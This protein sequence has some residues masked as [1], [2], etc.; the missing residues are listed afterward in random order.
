MIVLYVILAVVV[1]LFMVLIHE[2]GHYTA[3]RILKFKIDEFS[4]GFG[5][6]IFSRTNKRG[7]KISLR[8][9][10]LG[11]Y[12]AFA[13]EDGTDKNGNK[14][15]EGKAFTDQKAWKRIIV[16][17]A[18]AT[19]NFLTAIV[20]SFIL[21]VSV[22]YDIPEFSQAEQMKNIISY[23]YATE[24]NP[25]INMLQEGDV[26]FYVDG[27]KI[28]FAYSYSFPELVSMKTKEFKTWI[29]T[30]GNSFENH[31]PITFS[32]R[33]N[34]QMMDVPLYFTKVTYIKLD[35]NNK[36]IYKKDENNQIV[37]DET[38]TEEG[39]LKYDAY[40]LGGY[41]DIN[42]EN[43]IV[44]DSNGYMTLNYNAYS[45]YRH[46]FLEALA[47]CI[48]FAFGLAWIVLKS[49]WMLITFQVAISEMG[50]PITTIATIATSVQAN[51]ANMLVLIP[52]ISANL[53]VFNLLP[54][55]A[56]DGA[57]VAF[58]TVEWIRRKPINRELENM[59]HTL[60]LL[61]LF[62]FVI[63]VDILHFIL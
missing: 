45:T 18:G 31:K 46:S 9:F 38:T 52:L 11:G 63:L 62:G 15:K 54:V 7:E 44:V 59:I 8:I 5:K 4:I 10:P 35:S 30:E 20:F 34:G 57:H 37:I 55:P 16:F 6:A 19:F 41:I 32:V 1:L 60:G 24:Y 12:C 23:N 53:A 47:R 14:L 49:L 21:L 28:D 61:V 50:G 58:T 3:G 29:D 39:I 2:L 48:P 43:Q 17:L 36:P 51:F 40:S 33:R 13:G 26:V 22:G 56:L 27:I 25:E 42:N